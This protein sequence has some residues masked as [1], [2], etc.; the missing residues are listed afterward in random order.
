MTQ[1][2]IS[3]WITTQTYSGF[4][5]KKKGL[6]E[7]MGAWIPFPVKEI[8]EDNETSQLRPVHGIHSLRRDWCYCKN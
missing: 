3:S 4:K 8:Q 1:T 6:M 5:K 2:E 7:K